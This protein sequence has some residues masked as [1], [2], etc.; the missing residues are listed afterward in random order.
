MT[1]AKTEERMQPMKR[2]WARLAEAVRFWGA[3]GLVLGISLAVVASCNPVIM[4]APPGTTLSLFANPTFISAHGGVAEVSALL[5]MQTGVPVHDGTVVQFFTNLGHIEEQGKTNDGVARVKFISD[6]RSGTA[7]INAF[8]G[9]GSAPSNPTATATAPATATGT[10]TTAPGPSA[11]GGTATSQITILIGNVTATRIRVDAVPARITTSRSSQIVA[12]ALDTSG[13]PVPD[14]PIFFSING[15]PGNERLD[16][17]AGQP[18]F[19]DNNGRATDVL[20]TIAINDGNSYTVTVKAS[21]PTGQEAT[22]L[23]TIN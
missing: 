23:V 8:S 18:I 12:T 1:D 19:T 14:V 7:Q 20:R 4:V 6:S 15:N 5:Y 13:N 2:R 10:A 17:A 22:T 21:L 9:G 3:F 16:S 11:G